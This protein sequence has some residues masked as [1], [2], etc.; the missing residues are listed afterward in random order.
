MIAVNTSAL[1][2]MTKVKTRRRAV[3]VPGVPFPFAENPHRADEDKRR[4]VC[5]AER[6]WGKRRPHGLTRSPLRSQPCSP[7]AKTISFPYSSSRWLKPHGQG[8]TAFPAGMSAIAAR[9][10]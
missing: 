4:P 8:R 10:I 3:G 2:A 5:H 1:M 9:S 6:A 7:G